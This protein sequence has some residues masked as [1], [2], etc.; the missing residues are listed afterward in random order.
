MQNKIAFTVYILLAIFIIG[1]FIVSWIMYAEYEKY[2]SK[3][4]LLRATSGITG[5][6]SS[7]AVLLVLFGYK[8]IKIFAK[9]LDKSLH[10]S[11]SKYFK[12]YYILI[13][14]IMLLIFIINTS[15]SWTLF[16]LVMKPENQI[17][18]KQTKQLALSRG[19]FGT[20]LMCSLILLM[21][22]L[23]IFEKYI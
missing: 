7:L 20:F 4:K 21:T 22:R 5:V 10:G 23:H 1:I 12:K 9:E 13:W 3:I 11:L 8:A 6:F 17:N 15:I 14:V 2:D 19:I 16:G 18:F